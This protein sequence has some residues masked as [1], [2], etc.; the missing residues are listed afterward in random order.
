MKAVQLIIETSAVECHLKIMTAFFNG[1]ILKYFASTISMDTTET[2]TA[3]L[4][5]II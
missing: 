3:I 2:F 1:Y 5:K 4:T